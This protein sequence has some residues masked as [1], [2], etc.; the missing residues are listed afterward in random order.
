MRGKARGPSRSSRLGTQSPNLSFDF[1]RPSPP[2]QSINEFSIPKQDEIRLKGFR[3]SPL[4]ERFSSRREPREPAIA[5]RVRSE[6]G[7]RKLLDRNIAFERVRRPKFPPTF[8]VVIFTSTNPLCDV[9]E[10]EFSGQA[11]SFLVGR[12]ELAMGLQCLLHGQ[13]VKFVFN[14]GEIFGV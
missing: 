2:I 9:E 6:S 14:S 13:P 4:S 10:G 1:T 8:T 5:R 11:R 3:C 12:R 7:H